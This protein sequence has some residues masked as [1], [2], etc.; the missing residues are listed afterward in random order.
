MTPSGS[1]GRG[2]SFHCIIALVLVA[3]ADAALTE[4]LTLLIVGQRTPVTLEMAW[5]PVG[6]GGTP[7]ACVTRVILAGWSR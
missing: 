2:F 3:I 1:S 6:L 5:K 7:V 4:R